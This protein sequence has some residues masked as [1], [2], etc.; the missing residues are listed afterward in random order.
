MGSAEAR[1]FAGRWGALLTP[2]H[3]FTVS[4]GSSVA[5]AK[6]VSFSSKV[7]SSGSGSSFLL[8]R[9]STI[10]N[11]SLMS[12][13]LSSKANLR[14]A[15]LFSMNLYFLRERDREC[16]GLNPTNCFQRRRLLTTSF[17]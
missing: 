15:V 2:N 13:I 5:C 11:V 9:N 17:L 4:T 6:R 3:K 8:L 1:L 14:C 16:W 10:R 7:V 12:G